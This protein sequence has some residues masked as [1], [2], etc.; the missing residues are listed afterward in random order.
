MGPWRQA[1]LTSMLLQMRDMN[2]ANWEFVCQGTFDPD[3]LKEA[4]DIR[5]AEF[6]RGSH[7]FLYCYINVAKK[8][9]AQIENTFAEYDSLVA[10]SMQIKLTNL[11]GESKLIGFG[12]GY[13][14]KRHV[15]YKEIK[16]FQQ[17]G[18]S[19]YRL[20][21]NQDKSLD[22]NAYTFHVL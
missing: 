21:Q 15:I 18:S 10:D 3:R 12:F 19:S 2:K 17:M 20:W 11:P 8:R 1:I 7:G 5:C 16:K 4:L 9:F 14:Y 22:K 6:A 13:E